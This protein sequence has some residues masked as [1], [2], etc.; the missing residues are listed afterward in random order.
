MGNNALA[1]GASARNAHRWR[2]S[3]SDA[4]KAM[5]W[6]R[7]SSDPW[8]LAGEAQLAQNR[9]EDARKSFRTAISKDPHDWELWVELALASP[10]PARRRA[11]LVALHLNPL[12]P[13][14]AA[15]HPLLGLEP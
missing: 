10:Q 1:N 13:E 3:E 6:A 4:K 8:Q 9:L 5:R 11:A 2:D 12:S 7:W 15:S 14:I